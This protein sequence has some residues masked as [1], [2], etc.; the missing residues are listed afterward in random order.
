MTREVQSGGSFL[1][2]NGTAHVFGLGEDG[3]PV[4]VTVRWPDG[5]ESTRAGVSAGQVLVVSK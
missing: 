3:A 1:S 5:T 2:Q 4:D